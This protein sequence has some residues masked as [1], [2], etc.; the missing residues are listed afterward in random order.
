MEENSNFLFDIIES[1]LAEG[2]TERVH[3]RFP[4]EPNGYLHRQRQGSISTIRPRRSTAACSIC[5][6]TTPTPRRRTTSTSFPIRE[7]LE[8]LGAH[9]DAVFYGSDY[10]DKCY[11]FAVG[12][13][14]AGRRMSAT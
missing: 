10:F 1:D 11:E 3:T 7:D 13:I 6:T 4:P 8:W 12:L 5:A 2:R 9:P 14:K